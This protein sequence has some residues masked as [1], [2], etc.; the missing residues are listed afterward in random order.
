[1][2]TIIASTFIHIIATKIIAEEYKDG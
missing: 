2:L 1:M